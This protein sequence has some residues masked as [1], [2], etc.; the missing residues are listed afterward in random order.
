[1]NGAYARYNVLYAAC[2]SRP[3]T[4]KLQCSETWLSQLLN[5]PSPRKVIC[6]SPLIQVV[7]PPY[8]GRLAPL[9][10]SLAPLS[11]SFGPLIQVVGPLI[12]VVWPPYPGRLAPL[13]RSF[14]PLIQVVWPPYP[15]RLAPLS[16]S[17]GHNTI[18]SWF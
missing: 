18:W 1:M 7:W 16:R 3:V 12:Q 10:R 17:F 8:P 13:S 6:T 2:C 4:F 14:G 5:A 11:R 9:S 15:G